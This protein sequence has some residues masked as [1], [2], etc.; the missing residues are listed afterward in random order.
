MFIGGKNNRRREKVY[1]S[2][3]FICRYIVYAN[4]IL[5]LLLYIYIYIYSFNL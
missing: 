1:A 5:Q 3:T 4:T 2:F